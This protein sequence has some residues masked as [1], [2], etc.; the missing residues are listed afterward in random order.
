MRRTTMEPRMVE[1]LSITK[2]VAIAV[3]S[4]VAYLALV[5]GLIVYCSVRLMRKKRALQITKKSVYHYFL[6][7]SYIKIPKL[8][9]SKCLLILHIKLSKRS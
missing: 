2:T 6:S 9:F 5:I 1:N 4:A 7:L 8:L 3:C